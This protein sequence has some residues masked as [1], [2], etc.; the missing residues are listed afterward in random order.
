MM[1]EI[2]V[3]SVKVAII[4]PSRGLIFSKTADEIL[5]N[6]KGIPHKFFFSHGKPIPECF[7]TPTQLALKDKSISHLWFVEDDMVLPDGIL[8]DLLA[9]NANAVTC[10]YPVTKTGRG[11]VFYDGGGSVVFCGT[12]CLLVKRKIF[13]GLRAPY[14]TDKIRWSILN[15]GE[16]VKLVALDGDVDGYGLHDITYSIKLW[17]NGI[18]IKVLPIKLGQRRLIALGDSGSNNGAHK[19]EVWTKVVKNMRLKALQAQPVALGAKTKLVVVDTPSGG[20]TT[21]RKHA[22]S[23][24][25]QGLA[26]YPPKRFTIIDMNEIEI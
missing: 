19:I 22:D 13:N 9:E 21:S 8:Q 12:G 16:A 18:V 23:L 5:R 20:V 26:T 11:S 15:Y 10:D 17:N 24:V 25:A 2:I 1:G 14:F 4:L 6:L 3:L 7:E